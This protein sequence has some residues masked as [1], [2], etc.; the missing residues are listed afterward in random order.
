M[1]QNLERGARG[2]QLGVSG[3]GRGMGTRSGR[4][5]QG[6][7]RSG[8]GGGARHG[9][10]EVPVL[11]LVPWEL[12]NGEFVPRPPTS[13]QVALARA[14]LDR[15]N[16][17]ADR[18]GMDRRRFVQSA[19]GMAATLA[20][21][22]LAAC[23]SGSSPSAGP[24]STTIPL[25]TSAR[26][27]TS[28]TA[29]PGGT[30]EVPEPEDVPACEA[31]LS[32]QGEFIFDIH[33]HHVVPDGPWRQSAPAIASMISPLAP[34]S[35]TEGDPF[36][37]LDRLS[38]VQDLFLA[39]DTTVAML[40]DVPNSGPADAPLP[41]DDKVTTQDFARSLVDGGPDRVLVHDVIAPNYGELA[42]HLDGMTER[43]ESGRVAAF[44]AYTAW[45]PGQG[46]SLL[47]PAVGIPVIEHARGLGVRVFCGH[48]GLP[49]VGF[50]QNF[51]GPDDL[52]ALSAQYPDM[53]FVV[54][55]SAFERETREG[56]YDPA[57]AAR[58]TNSVLKAMDEHGVAPNS[59]L[60]VELGTT[61][62]EV[63]ADPDQAAHVLGKLLSRV[64]EDRVLWG[65]DAIWYGSPQPQIM[66]FRAF[67]ISELYQE[68]YGYPALTD[69]V[70]RKVLG[71]NG[72]QLMGLDPGAVHCAVDASRLEQAR[73]E[74]RLAHTSGDIIAPWRARG[75]VTRRQMLTWLRSGSFDLI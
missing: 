34:A 45:G 24:T 3:I 70:K 26:P 62:R 39:S 36:L 8:D 37:C 59:N 2:N 72:A 10:D 19:G 14:M 50:D 67:Q 25:G 33:T 38:Y 13:R 15:S 73:A 54:F 12:S 9:R 63:L 66:A 47:D 68:Q 35:C 30:Y 60:W 49:I 7:R 4:S 6:S 61:W 58:G 11:P 56:P 74:F 43:V 41:Y 21:F 40:S 17:A 31:A 65:T 42:P 52:V 46:Y 75:P 53:D 57:N 28:A 18:L 55:H 48:K 23:G 71:L 20:L 32:S 64:G 16:R 1:R 44:K 69:E 27:T 51:N 5:G 22:N 29:E